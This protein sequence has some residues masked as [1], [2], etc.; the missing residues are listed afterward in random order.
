MKKFNSLRENTLEEKLKASDPAGEWIRD[1]VHSD[2]PKFAG[3]SKKERIRMALGASYGARRNE[4]SQYEA[5]DGPL[6]QEQLDELSKDT[7]KSYVLKK[8]E[9]PTTTKKDVSNLG[10]AYARLKNYKPTSEPVK[11]DAVTDALG[12]IVDKVFNPN[13]YGETEKKE[14]KPKETPKKTNEQMMP[15]K[16]EKDYRGPEGGGSGGGSFRGRV[17]PTLGAE[18][19]MNQGRKEPS[20]G[21][22]LPDTVPPSKTNMG[23]LEPSFKEKKTN[24]DSQLDQLKAMR[25]NPQHT[26]TP[27]HKGQLDK[28]IKLAQ[29]R[30]DLDQGEVMG[31]D[32]KPIPVLPPAD[33]AKKN[34]NFY[35][36]A[37]GYVPRII[38]SRRATVTTVG[39]PKVP[40]DDQ[41]HTP[42]VPK[43]ERDKKIKAALDTYSDQ[44]KKQ[45][46]NIKEA[47]DYAISS[48]H[49]F[50]DKSMAVKVKNKETGQEFHHVGSPSHLNNTLKSRYSITNRLM[51]DK[52]SVKT[53]TKEEFEQ[54]DE[55]SKKTIGSYIKKATQD[56]ND[57]AY[58]SGANSAKGQGKRSTQIDRKIEKRVSN[59]D[60]ATDRLTK[61]EFEQ[62]DE[63]SK[64][65]LRRY[66]V[67]AALDLSK[68]SFATGQRSGKASWSEN[69]E[70]RKWDITKDE[71][72]NK[73]TRRV[74][75]ITKAASR[76][77][78]EDVDQIDEKKKIKHKPATLVSVT[79]GAVKSTMGNM[80]QSKRSK[81][82]NMEAKEYILGDISSR[83]LE[84]AKMKGKDPCWKDYKM[85]GTKMK[86]GKEVP[87]CVPKKK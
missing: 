54:L 59:M 26:S 60:K 16:G 41:P 75:G 22:R 68:R 38:T 81:G 3:K 14:Q 29:D 87:N 76:L 66:T 49:H 4:E 13:R 78:K 70:H 52:N 62:L 63:I 45:Y 85:I 42:T 6:T 32:S 35:K 10:K 25:N 80:L 19:T 46:P 9:Q 17:E 34:P 8:M 47:S 37:Y 64:Q 73:T 48:T 15:R 27:E 24:E 40:E 43:T 21:A 84:A 28:R 39:N 82:S 30:K 61:E 23:R 51:W 74:V 44:M 69:P 11:E 86:S 20:M 77:A 31:K 65:K 12:K 50:P 79:S 5:D 56:V 58:V 36:E 33:F 71:D 1:F 2:N 83:I 67:D 7:V 57:K 18:P 55:I 72:K 53:Y